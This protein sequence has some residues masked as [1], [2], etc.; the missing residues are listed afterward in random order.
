MRGQ[1]RL[2]SWWLYR[3]FLLPFFFLLITGAGQDDAYDFVGPHL[4][5]R[6][7][8]GSLPQALASSLAVQVNSAVQRIEYGPQGVRVRYSTVSAGAAL[9]FVFLKK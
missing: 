8:F 6:D 2:G 5:V 4:L 9:F 3:V 1:Y 7:G